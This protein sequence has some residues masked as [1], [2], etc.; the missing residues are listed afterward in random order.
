MFNIPAVQRRKNMLEESIIHVG[1]CAI[2]YQGKASTIEP[3]HEISTN[4][5]F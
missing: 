5:A 3:V 2:K 4:V 1:Y